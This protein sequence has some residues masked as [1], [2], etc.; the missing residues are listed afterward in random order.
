MS[1]R[2]RRES[3]EG[4]THQEPSR[5]IGRN[6]SL[7]FTDMLKVKRSQKEELQQRQQQQ[8]FKRQSTPS[9]IALKS[10]KSL[11]MGVQ[12]PAGPAP[13]Q[14]GS[15][16]GLAS[17]PAVRKGRK[18]PAERGI[19]ANRSFTGE[20]TMR[21]A[22]ATQAATEQQQAPRRERR[23]ASRSRERRAGSSDAK[24]T[25]S[26]TGQRRGRKPSSE[27][28]SSSRPRQSRSRSIDE[29]YQQQRA[30][31]GL[32]RS[33]RQRRAKTEP[34]PGT[35]RERRAPVQ[36]GIGATKSDA[37]M[38]PVIRHARSPS[39]RA[40]RAPERRGIAPSKSLP[41]EHIRKVEQMRV[42][43]ES[44]QKKKT[45][46]ES[47]DSDVD[48]DS[49]SS[50]ESTS[51]DE[52]DQV[53]Q[54][55]SERPS[56]GWDMVQGEVVVV[57]DASDSEQDFDHKQSH[58]NIKPGKGW[59]Q[60]INNYDEKMKKIHS[61]RKTKKT[62]SK[63]RNN[64]NSSLKTSGSS[65]SLRKRDK[66]R[67]TRP[68]GTSKTPSKVEKNFSNSRISIDKSTATPSPRH[69]SRRSSM[70]SDG[71]GSR[72]LKKG[73]ND[74]DPRKKEKKAF[75]SFSSAS[76]RGVSV[77]SDS[78]SEG[79]KDYHKSL[80]NHRPSGGQWMSPMKD[81]SKQKL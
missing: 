55:K 35:K 33:E 34:D 69:G 62:K 16:D 7:P 27:R 60:P 42:K 36:R 45:I 13:H 19:S 80:R 20:K 23:T 77:D 1:S 70:S 57:E 22:A 75:D 28:R 65:S 44:Q 29:K 39:R 2:L 37:A 6:K 8:N 31:A 9:R 21:R 3:G 54:A 51:S 58:R 74:T 63:E 78:D 12:R 76:Q 24:R 17:Q 64:S 18:A 71:S 48:Y 38:Q 73:M 14:N 59:L 30:A 56:C 72:R 46:P 52:E 43:Q 53:S 40:R 26:S 67:P 47:S 5:G 41:S 61:D 32:I 68:S 79:E 15:M 66:E 4:L 10:S 49:P 25:S 11:P 81:R 50:D